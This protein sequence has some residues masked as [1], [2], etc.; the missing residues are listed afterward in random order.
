TICSEHF[1][2]RYNAKRHNLK[3]HRGR[4]EIVRLI[5]YLA[6]RQSGK[7]Q[8]NSPFW[9]SDKEKWRRPLYD[10]YTTST[11]TN[12]LQPNYEA[13][14]P[15]DTAADEQQSCSQ[16][17][18]KIAELKALLYKHRLRLNQDPET[19]LRSILAY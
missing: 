10:S 15:N 4:S 9:Y 14:R 18:I 11:T 8:P 3:A 6:G 16:R 2:R 7:Y 1:T 13:L 12:R 19:I 5:D 17:I